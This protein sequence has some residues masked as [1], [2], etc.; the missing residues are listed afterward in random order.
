MIGRAAKYMMLVLAAPVLSAATDKDSLDLPL[1]GLQLFGHSVT[2]LSVG[3]VVGVD[4]HG[5][6]SYVPTKGDDP[7][8]F[9]IPSQ[10]PAS[11]APGFLLR[12]PLGNNSSENNS[13][14]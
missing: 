11:K 1:G 12:I 7:Y 3:S 9:V 2:A 10:Q 14:R 8:Y 5:G 6:G 4:S 13:S